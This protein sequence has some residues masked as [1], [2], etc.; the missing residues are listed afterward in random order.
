MLAISCETFSLQTVNVTSPQDCTWCLFA[1]TLVTSAFTN[2]VK[3]IVTIRVI[4]PVKT[5]FT[6]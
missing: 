4:Y 5:L 6:P 2:I 3:H 1:A